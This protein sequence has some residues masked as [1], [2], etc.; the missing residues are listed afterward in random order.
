MFK[1]SFNIPVNYIKAVVYTLQNKLLVDLDALGSDIFV[2][3]KIKQKLS[4]AAADIQHPAVRLNQRFD[5]FIIDPESFCTFN[6][7]Y[8]R[9]RGRSC[10][11]SVFRWS[12]KENR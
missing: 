4:V 7:F 6:A 1:P 12:W 8:A 9:N 3:L 2:V 10:Q 11:T 5:K